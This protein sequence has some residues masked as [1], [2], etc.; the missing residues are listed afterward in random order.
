MARLDLVLFG[1]FRASVGARSI[2]LPLRKAQALLAYLALPPGKSHS[3]EHLA[4]LLWGDNPD[5]QARNS[6]RQTLFALRTA[7]GDAR[8]LA[9][10]GDR[11]CLPPDEVEVD[12]ETFERLAGDGSEAALA[13][14]AALY[15]GDLLEGLDVAAVGFNA[16]LDATRARLRRTA[17]V[18]MRRLLER[19]AGADAIGEAVATAERLLRADPLQEA[20]HRMLIRLYDRQGRRADA[21]RQY[22]ACADLLR[23]ELGTEP[24]PATDAAYRALVPGRALRA[25]ASR[26]P[27]TGRG[28]ERA[29]FVG[30]APQLT[31]L[32]QRLTNAASGLGG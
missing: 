25:A 19:Q 29:P 23:R 26:A 24:E 13:Q 31:A 17:T 18:A 7:L 9:S 11:V 2:L 30:R 4:T 22:R 8:R 27:N 10:D 28:G 15:R 12:V 16:W 32:R 3:R 14:A 20:V 6:L 5:D 1:E 21:I